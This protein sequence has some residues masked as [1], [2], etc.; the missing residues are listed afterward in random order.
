MPTKTPRLVR[1]VSPF[2]SPASMLPEQAEHFLAEDSALW[3]ILSE[4]GLL[5]ERQRR[6]GEP[7]V[8]DNDFRLSDL[9]DWEMPTGDDPWPTI[10]RLVRKVEEQAR[11]RGGDFVVVRREQR[12]ATMRRSLLIDGDEVLWSAPVR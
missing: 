3:A 7:R 4:Q 2:G 10:R 1:Y 6:I 9:P 11:L 8:G 5:D 12:Y